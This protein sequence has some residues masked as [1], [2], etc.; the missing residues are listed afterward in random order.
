MQVFRFYHSRALSCAVMWPAGVGQPLGTS[1][2]DFRSAPTSPS[3]AAF[4]FKTFPQCTT[5]ETLDSF[6]DHVVWQAIRVISD[7]QECWQQ[8]M[9]FSLTDTSKGKCILLLMVSAS[10]PDCELSIQVSQLTDQ[11]CCFRHG[12][13]LQ[14]LFCVGAGGLGCGQWA[15]FWAAW[16]GLPVWQCRFVPHPQHS[17][18]TKQNA[19]LQMEVCMLCV[20]VLHF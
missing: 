19:V 17:L 15:G 4:S 11:M 9:C 16:A 14:Q 12:L 6:I 7:L 5:G 10:C 3:S 13:S 2:F 18:H 1:V 20:G 8:Q